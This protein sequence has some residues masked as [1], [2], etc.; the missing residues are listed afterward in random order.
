M[1]GRYRDRV[2]RW[3]EPVARL[4]VRV[5]IRPNYLTVLGLALSAL[6]AL[7][8]A[9]NRV[10]TGGLLL[11]AAGAADLLDGAVARVSGQA[12]PFGAFL[13]SVLDRYSDLIILAGLALLFVR[14]GRL[15]DLLLTLASL[16]GSIMV[17]YTRARAES[18]GADCGVG[19]MERG[20]R[21]IC[22]I[23]GALADLMTPILWLLAIGSNLT[24]IQRIHHTWRATRAKA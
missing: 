23:V 20:E 18:I 5:R 6:A 19:L 24:A 11:M 2:D 15:P 21:M 17:S 9:A 3:S 1:L 16:V 8:F 12:T 10:R 7:A 13:D 4:L 14:L 22:L